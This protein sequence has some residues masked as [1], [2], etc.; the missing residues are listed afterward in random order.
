LSKKYP[1]IWSA[2]TCFDSK[3]NAK[4]LRET[5][6]E[7]GLDYS[8]DKENRHYSRIMVII[9]FPQFA[10][11]FKFLVAKPEFEINIFDTR[12][13]HSGVYHHI[14]VKYINKSNIKT[15]KKILNTWAK[16]LPRKPY[17][18][19]FYE[20]LRTGFVLP[21]FLL[22]KRKWRMMGVK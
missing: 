3:Y 19:F 14:E 4:V 11:V 15:V 5:L 16:K 21:E 12:P 22:A 2:T 13:T 20:R 7:L 18:F 9:P 8:R 17:K 1:P 6:D 10:Y